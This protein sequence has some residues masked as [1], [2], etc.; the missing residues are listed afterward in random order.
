M[1]ETI[2]DPI[3]ALHDSLPLEDPDR[4]ALE[5]PAVEAAFARL[6]AMPPARLVTW[7]GIVWTLR[8]CDP[9]GDGRYAPEDIEHCQRLS[10]ARGSELIAEYGGRAVA[11]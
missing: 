9:D 4:H 6:A 5:D 1:S 3:R 8:G 11:A 2:P 7:N 10:M